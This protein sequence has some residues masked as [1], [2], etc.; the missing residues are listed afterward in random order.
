MNDTAVLHTP[1]A[2]GTISIFGVH[3]PTVTVVG[4]SIMLPLAAFMAWHLFR[5]GPPKR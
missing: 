5:N 4:L 3:V 2:I 1:V